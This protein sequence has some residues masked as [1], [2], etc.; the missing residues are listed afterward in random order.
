MTVDLYQTPLRY[1][2]VYDESSADGVTPRPHW[3]HL[4]ESLREIGPE[5]LGRRWGHAERRIR[6][7]GITYNIYSDP[8]GVNRPWKIDIIPLLIPADE[9]RYIE[10]GIVQRAQLLSLLLEDLYGAQ[11]LV[12]QG[13]FPAALLY[14]NP[15]FL[16]P[17]VGVRVPA[18]TY[19][20]MLAVDLA[21]SPDGQWWVL[22]DRTQAPSGSGYALENRTIVSD[23][24]PDIF[25]T[26]NVLRLSHFFRS[27][28]EVLTNLS[29]RN[30]PR[31]VL[32]T[33][34]PYNETYFEH[35]YL[36]RYL[37]LT[38]VVGADLTVRD[39]CVYLKTVD[40]LEQVDVILRRVD[41]SFC[42]PL[43][44]RGDSLLG[45]P[46]LVD[47]IVAGNVKVVNALG[48]GLIET[49]AVMPFLPGLSRHVLGETLKLPSVATWWCGQQHT[50]DWVLDHL[51]SVVVKPAF[52]SLGMEPVF[53]AE[54][55]DAER[56]KFAQQLRARP[57]EYVAQE[58]IALSTAP[59][60]EDGHLNSRSVVLR[61]YVLNTGSGWIAIPGGLTRVAE[62][63]GSVVSMQR[64]GHAKD[65]WVL[66]DSPV[67]TFS[68]LRPRNEP[69]ELRRVSRVVSSSVADN[70]FWLGRYAERA[71][72]IARILRPMISRV[73]QS[74]KTELGC[75]LRLHSCLESRH[76][77]L[78]KT[79]KRPPTSL[80]L[81]QEIISLMSDVKRPDS[82]ASTLEEVSRIGGN[83]RD[84]LSADMMSL[85]GQLRDAI[86]IGHGTQFLEYPAMLTAC[87][88][89]L[90]AFS[91]MERENINRGLGWFFLTLGRRLERAMYLTRQL[92]EITT[93][94]VE[95]DWLLLEC[96]LE[97]ADSSMTYRTRYYT[98][99]QPLAVLDVLMADESNP[100]SL[101]FQLSH[102]M[103]LY[104]KLPRH[105]PDDLEAMRNALA[106]LRSFDL[107]ELKYPLPGAATVAHDSEGL[108]RLE[109]FLRELE[110]LLPSWSNNISSRYF[111]HARTL[112]ITVGQ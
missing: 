23:V 109:R 83:V 104:Q 28:L 88:E 50:L 20:H 86:Q 38:L 45:V 105:L 108:S 54:L 49:A 85:I 35:S 63:E 87:L 5:E 64:G 12:A 4:M 37:G 110:R 13:H 7:N 30:D 47:A 81:E 53:A 107:R 112:P 100:R 9:W 21:R 31:I 60:W 89:L 19:L 15:A 77:K 8:L 22:A 78:P 74:D 65:A 6:E 57:H 79:K 66:W 17:L 3:A 62:M 48:S 25:R 26:S 73:R 76:S 96:L 32:L 84:R 99:L 10:A 68:M 70:V 106:L 2:A 91:G 29:T 11:D 72:N 1:G 51:D 101:D 40:R 97:V 67:D 95:E 90:S 102:L 16:R 34:G 61:T 55:P 71:E 14:A 33:P 75:L 41:D 98:T 93:P 80:E 24:L 92:R 94:L 18:H 58:Q 42:D 43:E 46:G 36:A 103:D 111:S 27:Q 82:L 69:V 52:P 56:S 44:L 39:R 59:V